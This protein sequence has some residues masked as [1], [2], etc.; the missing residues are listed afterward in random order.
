MENIVGTLGQ[1]EEE[2]H[3]TKY[4][5]DDPHYPCSVVDEQYKASCYFLQTSRMMQL[6]SGNFEEIAS[7]CSKALERFQGHCFASM[8]RD[9]GGVHRG[10]PA[11]A[12]AACSYAPAG[13]NRRDCLT[14]AVQDSFWDPTGQDEALQFCKLVVNNEEKAACY[15]TIAERAPQ[16]LSS[17]TDVPKFC[18]QVE[19]TYRDLCRSYIPKQ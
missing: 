10:N 12:I 14:G 4:L 13:A 5:N 9:V 1:G 7:A 16:I 15:R 6:F 8:G 3:Y 19:P 18:D 11:G 2:G 17:A